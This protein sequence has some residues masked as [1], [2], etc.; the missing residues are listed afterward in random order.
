MSLE[1]AFAAV[2]RHDLAALTALLDADGQL[3]ATADGHG[4]SL[5]NLAVSAGDEQAVAL[6]LERGAHVERANVHGWTP[7]HQA[8]HLGR[9]ELAQTLLDAGAP[10]D[11]SARGDGGTPLTVALFWGQ[12][13]TAE[14][15]AATPGGLAPVNLRVAA[16]LG[17]TDVVERL[18]A[19]D[20]SLLP[21][22]GA[23]RGFYRPHGGF[24][25]WQP[26]QSQTE[27]RDEALAWA[28]RNDR[29][30]A[31][32]LLV[33]RG[34]DPERDVY[35]GTPLVWAAACGA[36]DAAARLVTVGADPNGRS[37]FGGPGHGESVTALHVA[38]E[39]GR[40]DVVELLLAVGADRTARDALHRAT[41]AEWAEHAGREDAAARLRR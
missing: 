31:V 20:G 14:L 5:L 35:R 33:A 1:Q 40:L 24:P 13:A 4:N 34:A 29:A 8:A 12:R 6:L 16:G 15:L 3:V 28:A 37:S 32:S 18:F 30:D 39:G 23:G 21:Q 7:L 41:P 36:L 22:A 9:V 26:S 25:A 19:R 2:E 10:V 17:L 27:V 38:A 11:G